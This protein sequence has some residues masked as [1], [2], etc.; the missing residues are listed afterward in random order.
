VTVIYNNRTERLEVDLILC[1]GSRYQFGAYDEARVQI[2]LGASAILELKSERATANGSQIT[3]VNPLLIY[4]EERDNTFPEGVYDVWVTVIDSADSG[5]RKL[6]SRHQL[7]VVGVPVVSQGDDY[8][9][10][11]ESSNTISTSSVTVSTSSVSSLTVAQSTSSQSTSS[12]STS[13][14]SSGGVTSSQS[15][16]SSSESQ[17]TSS[18]SSISTSSSASSSSSESSRSDQ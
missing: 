1:D 10:S 3:K 16:S 18:G 8:D 11:S 4:L 2:G 14:Q 15:S 7:T 17:S 13:S 12:E 5:R 9:E 6:A